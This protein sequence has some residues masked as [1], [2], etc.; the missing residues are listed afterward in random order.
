MAAF[1]SRSAIAP[2][3]DLSAGCKCPLPSLG[4]IAATDIPSSMIIGH[5]KEQARL[6][7]ST[8]KRH[9]VSTA[10]RRTNEGPKRKN[11]NLHLG[12]LSSEGNDYHRNLTPANVRNKADG[13]LD[14][15]R[16]K[17]KKILTV[18]VEQT[19]MPEALSS[20]GNDG[21]QNLTTSSV[22]NKG[23]LGKT[24]PHNDYA[25][26]DINNFHAHIQY[27]NGGSE[28]ESND[29][30]QADMHS[31]FMEL[32]AS[33]N[34]LIDIVESLKSFNTAKRKQ[35]KVNSFRTKKMR[36]SDVSLIHRNAGPQNCAISTTQNESAHVTIAG[37]DFG[38]VKGSKDME[39]L[40][41][42]NTT[43]A[44]EEMFAM[45]YFRPQVDDSVNKG[46]G[47]CV[48]KISGQIYHWIGAMFPP[49]GDASWFLQLYIYDTEHEV[50][51]RLRHFGI[52][53]G[54]GLDTQI[55][56]SLVSL[57]AFLDQHNELVQIFRI[58]RNKCRGRSL[59]D[60][61]I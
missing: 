12:A 6:S 48:F 9:C 61:K 22:T 35:P 20:Q 7:V 55:V 26:N 1:G 57:V 33:H 21:P 10:G 38:M 17:P 19:L 36:K 56:E 16:L 37:P 5:E 50:A 45:T 27:A 4:A 59:P 30:W 43:S 47:P 32:G 46:R 49:S 2:D 54:H 14:S 31:I 34:Y 40:N 41:D 51:N 11:Q 28:V 44:A 3:I 53:E 18:R 25:T 42:P 23:L 39:T 15:T 8:R 60:F 29:V 13:L 58:A 24:W 52:V